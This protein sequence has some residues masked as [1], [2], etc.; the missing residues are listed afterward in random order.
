M[1]ESLKTE[2]LGRNSPKFAISNHFAIGYLPEILSASITEVSGPLL[3][4]VRPF[5]YVMYYNGGAHKSITGTF[6]FFR[7]RYAEECWGTQ[8]SRQF[9]K[10]HECVCCIE[11]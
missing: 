10:Q 4:T 7:S 6:T 1:L 3:A 2:N 9:E 8:L 11:W 5:A